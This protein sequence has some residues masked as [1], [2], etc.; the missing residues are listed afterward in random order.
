MKSIIIIVTMLL[1]S[2]SVHAENE[3]LYNTLDSVV[4]NRHKYTKEKEARLSM[5]KQRIP[6]ITDPALKLE[7]Y[8]T[9]YNE[10]HYFR[11]DSAMVYV[12]KGLELAKK[13]G[14]GRYTMLNTIH[15]ATLLSAS[16]LYSEAENLIKP[17]DEEKMD[18]LLKYEYNL[19]LYWLYTYWKDYANSSEYAD[20]YWEKKI[21]CLKKTIEL[22]RNSPTEYYYLLGE[23]EMYINGDHKK[24]LA[25]YN[26]VLDA[27]MEN[28]RLYS[29]ACFAAACCYNN[30][31]DY[32]RYEEYIVRTAITDIKTPVKENLSLQ[33]VADWLFNTDGNIKR[34][35]SYINVAIEDAKFYNNRLR[36]LDSSDKLM[37]IVPK[38][39]SMLEAQNYAL[40][41]ALGVCGVL[42]VTLV[43]AT[44][45]IV[46]QNKLLIHRRKEIASNNKQLSALNE[47]LTMKNGWLVNI[48]TR[49]ENLAKLYIDLCSKYIDRLNNYQKLVVRKIKA[50]QIDELLSKTTS[51]KLSD[52]DATTFMS[53]FDK[54]FLELYPS[55]VN[56]L[57][58]LLTDGSDV[59]TKPG[60]LTTELRIFALIRLGV[61]DSSEIANL[62]FYTPRTIYN[63]RSAMKA[64]AINRETFED[65]V[66]RLC[67]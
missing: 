36:M 11:Y 39:K 22:A 55:F 50:K 44:V 56:E 4:A 62:L 15:K 47:E 28:T 30:L 46:R 13:T 16:G 66:R 27:E 21:E 23:Y 60:S 63:Y 1:I 3:V 6:S 31:K 51:S 49:R 53:H 29:T 59:K 10:Y 37:V 42:V 14:N 38:Y 57:N 33:T 54:A 40:I 20:Q 9:I 12:L 5:L 65:D 35:E 61:K 48:N 18:S 58:A 2:T 8:N 19:T 64:K 45:F 67:T 7:M 26:K 34:A 24:A 41:W 32:V 52:E 43:V 17:L 25:Y